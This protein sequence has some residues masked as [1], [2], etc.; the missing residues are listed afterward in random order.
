MNR[1]IITNETFKG[2]EYR[3]SALYDD[4]KKMVEV[5]PEPAMA[6]NTILGNIYIARVENVVKNLNAAFVKISPEQNCYLPLEDVK[7]PIFTKKV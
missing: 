1:Y 6:D 5:L 2:Q 7:N 3:I 4:K